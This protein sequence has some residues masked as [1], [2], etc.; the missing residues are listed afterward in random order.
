[1]KSY[2]LVF[3]YPD[4]HIEEDFDQFMELEKAVAYGEDLLG[5][6]V[7]TEGVFKPNGEDDFGFRK[8]K[9]PYFMV[10]EIEDGNSK[11]VHES[12]HKK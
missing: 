11:L 8:K 12:K 10:Y 2:K 9:Q 5:Q 6:V 4:G 7:N 1:M 3:A